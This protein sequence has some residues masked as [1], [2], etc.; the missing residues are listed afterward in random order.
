VLPSRQNKQLP[1]SITSKAGKDVVW[2]CPVEKQIKYISDFPGVIL[3]ANLSGCVYLVSQVF[4]P[5]A[6]AV[7]HPH[8]TLISGDYYFQG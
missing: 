8:I 6:R 4:H 3:W 1:S 7:G 5:A 2:F